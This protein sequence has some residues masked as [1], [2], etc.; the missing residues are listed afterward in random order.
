MA[1]LAGDLTQ[2]TDVHQAV[3]DLVRGRE[4]GADH[5][6]HLVRADNRMLIQILQDPVPVSRRTTEP[7]GNEGTMLFA[8]KQYLPRGVGQ[9]AG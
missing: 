4:G 5:A 3:D 1:G 8:E 6:L 9:P 7:F 2:N